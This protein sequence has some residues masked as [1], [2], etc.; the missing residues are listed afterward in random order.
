VTGNHAILYLLT[1]YTKKEE[2]DL[3]PDRKKGL[4]AVVEEI[5]R[6]FRNRVQ[7]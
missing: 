6:A 3:T 7:L 2:S 4:C 1:L 5:K